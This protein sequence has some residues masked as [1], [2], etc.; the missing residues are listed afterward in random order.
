MLRSGCLLD[1]KTRTWTC[2]EPAPGHSKGRFDARYA[3]AVGKASGIANDRLPLERVE[4]LRVA[5]LSPTDTAHVLLR[6]PN[7]D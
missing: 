3:A 1:P 7:R 6:S 4:R 2:S 5:G